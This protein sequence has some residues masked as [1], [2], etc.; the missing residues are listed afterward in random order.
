MIDESRLTFDAGIWNCLTRAR[1]ESILENENL[2]LDYYRNRLARHLQLPDIAIQ[3]DID[4]LEKAPPTLRKNSGI[5]EGS[6]DTAML[7]AQLGRFDS[8]FTILSLLSKSDPSL[9]NAMG[10]L[11]QFTNAPADIS[12]RQRMAAEFWVGITAWTMPP[13]YKEAADLLEETLAMNPNPDRRRS[14]YLSVAQYASAAGDTERAAT[15]LNRLMVEFAG[16]AGLDEAI[17]NHAQS[18]FGRN[19][20]DRAKEWMLRLVYNGRTNSLSARAHLELAEIYEKLNDEGEMVR[21]LESAAHAPPRATNHSVMDMS[22]TEQ[23]AVVRLGQYYQHK[24]DAARALDYF[25]AW[26]PGSGGC[27]NCM[28]EFA[29]E[30][31]LYIS[32]SLISLGRTNEALQQHLLPHV[33]NGDGLY[34]DADI[35]KLV[36]QIYERINALPLLRDRLSTANSKAAQ[37]AA[38]LAEIRQLAK[39]RKIS[40]LIGHLKDSGVASGHVDTDF[41]RQSNWHAVAAAEALSEMAGEELPLLIKEADKLPANTRQW[42]FYALGLCR[43]P[44]ATPF[45]EK[46]VQQKGYGDWE[47][48]DIQY[49][50]QLRGVK[51]K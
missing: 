32:Q 38:T 10:A 11:Q 9:T 5:W 22:D 12:A 45:L 19:E 23:T 29:W 17:F 27:G 30:R 24:G 15:Y 1:D 13:H 43:N 21:H 36:V 25:R 46:L 4:L 7:A 26:T 37:V 47:L 6:L 50:L 20:F 16:S 28:A 49:A 2:H 51:S 3:S 48:R 8:A 35:P 44:D 33:L 31:D 42:V 41:I 40:L 14:L 18:L 39:E 34:W